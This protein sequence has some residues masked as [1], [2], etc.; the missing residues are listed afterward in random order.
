V[1]REEK[2]APK[3][4]KR[5]NTKS[6]RFSEREEVN[7]TNECSTFSTRR[8]EGSWVR[9]GDAQLRKK[10]KKKGEVSKD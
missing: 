8:G 4:I 9:E 10:E 2:H 3:T 1:I 5:A 7:I 6:P